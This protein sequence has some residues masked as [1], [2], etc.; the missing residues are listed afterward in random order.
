MIYEKGCSK[1][2]SKHNILL[3]LSLLKPLEKEKKMC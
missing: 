1:I 3:I 2:L